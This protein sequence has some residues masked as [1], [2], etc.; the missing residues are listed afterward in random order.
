MKKLALTVGNG[1]MGDDGAGP[2]LARMM[3]LSPIE[4]WEALDGGSVPENVLHV[5]HAISPEEVLVIDA[6]DM[7]LAPGEVRY[8][9]PE[10]VGDPFFM[11]THALPI[12]Y[13]VQSLREFVPK[14]ELLGIQPDIVA[15]GYPLTP[16]VR[17]AVGRVYESLKVDILTWDRL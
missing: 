16:T 3:R 14:V 11:N 8:I 1:M 5:I 6:A 12:S 7:D 2:L 9:S 13:L 10:K 17:Q 4:G 15:F